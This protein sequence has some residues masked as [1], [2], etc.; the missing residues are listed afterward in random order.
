MRYEVLEEADAWVVRS[1]GCELARY[2]QQ[3]E[4]LNDVASRLREADASVA[5][6]VSVR[7]AT[8]AA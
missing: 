6:S 3:D 4:A 7:Y 8:R 1:E 5:S 2:R